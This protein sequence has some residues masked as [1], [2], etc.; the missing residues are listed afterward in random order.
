ME[1]Q[2]RRKTL[3]KHFKD[4]NPS[5]KSPRQMR[6][7]VNTSQRKKRKQTLNKNKRDSYANRT[8]GYKMTI[9]HNK[10]DIR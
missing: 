2:K 7:G 4:R 1:Y 6:V 8:H 9:H 5:I 10:E 3:Y